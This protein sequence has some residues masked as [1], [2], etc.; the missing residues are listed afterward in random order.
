MSLGFLC[1]VV[2]LPVRNLPYLNDQLNDFSTRNV[3]LYGVS[4]L[5]DINFME[6]RAYN[7]TP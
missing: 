5:M 7:E 4:T 3:V 2:H 1:T 6:Q